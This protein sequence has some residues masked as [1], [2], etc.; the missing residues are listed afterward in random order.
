MKRLAVAGLV[1]ALMLVWRAQREAAVPVRGG[2]GSAV[3]G[4]AFD[5]RGY[6]AMERAR[7]SRVT[8]EFRERLRSG[9]SRRLGLPGLQ[10]AEV[11]WSFLEM[12]TG[13]DVPASYEGDWSWM[14]SRLHDIILNTPRSELDF[15]GILAPF[16]IVIGKDP[17]G[18]TLVMNELF[19]RA[20]QA[21]RI[22]FWGGFHA[23]ENLKMRNWAGD[24][25]EHA[26]LLPGA[27]PFAAA[28]AARLK[29]GNAAVEGSDREQVL[30]QSLSPRLLERVQEARPEWFSAPAPGR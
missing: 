19:H 3:V 26:A 30:R 25:Y 17:L 24:L 1:F 21:W 6:A 5:P 10:S 29:L 8:D 23:L 13:L 12:L 20:P 16:F 15:V 18:A 4:S 7:Q 22:W 28:L 11:S 14:F 2:F 27:P 9:V